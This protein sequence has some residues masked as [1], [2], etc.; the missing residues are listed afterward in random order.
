MSS[1][2]GAEQDGRCCAGRGRCRGPS[3]AR[4]V[5]LVVPL[6]SGVAVP[7]VHIV[8]VVGMRHGRVAAIGAV[9]VFVLSAVTCASMLCS[10]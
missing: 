3:T 9:H 2:G 4:S 7:V 10:S 6:M 1:L 5:L 8:D